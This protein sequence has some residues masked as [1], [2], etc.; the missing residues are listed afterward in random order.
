MAHKAHR[1]RRRRN[2]WR[3]KAEQAD[4]SRVARLMAHIDQQVD[5]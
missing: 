3:A 2:L 5:R 4:V 1:D